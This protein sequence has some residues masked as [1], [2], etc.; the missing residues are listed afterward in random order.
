MKKVLH[1]LDENLECTICMVLLSVFTVILFIQVI[2]R[3]V[4][5]NSLSWSEE[6][7]RYLF[8]WL[9]FIGIS[10]GAKQM[11]HLKIDV[12]LNIFPKKFRPY[13]IIFADMVV[14]IFSIMVIYSAYSIVTQYMKMGS[15]SPALRIPTWFIQSSSIVGYG[16]TTIRQ[17]QTIIYR[18]KELKAGDLDAFEA[19][20]EEVPL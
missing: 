6:L 13:V 11:K 3:Y 20:D 2:M 18:I 5:N 4:F 14:L 15:A 12:F 10:Y 7:A 1:W 17:I 19:N 9:V 16:L 8:I